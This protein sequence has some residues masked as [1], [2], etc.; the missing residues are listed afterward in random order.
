M[1]KKRTKFLLN[2]TNVIL[3][4]LHSFSIAFAQ[5]KQAIRINGIAAVVGDEII[6]EGD[7]KEQMVIARMQGFDVDNECSV[8]ENQM[9]N[10]LL[11]VK[12]KQDTLIKITDKELD[13]EV[14]RKIQNF[15]LRAGSE[16]ELLKAFRMSSMAEVKMEAKEYVKEEYYGERK[17][18][19]IIGKIDASPNDVRKYFN[20]IKDQLPEVKESVRISHI[21]MYPKLFEKHKEEIRKKLRSMKEDIEAGI[22]TFELKA[23]IYS[24]DPGSAKNGGFYGNVRRGKMVKEFDAV[25]FNLQ[26]G[27]I[28]EPFETEYGFHIIKLEKRKGQALDLRHILLTAKPTDEE[29]L[30]TRAK[31][32]SIKTLIESGK[33]TFKEAV[34]KFSDDKYTRNNEGVVVDPRTGDNQFEKEAL[35]G[36]E[37][38]AVVALEPGQ[39]SYPFE[40]TFEKRTV[41]RM[42]KLDEIIPAH[43]MNLETDYAKIKRAVVEKKK[44]EALKK[45]IKSNISDVFISVSPGFRECDF[46]L[47]WFNDPNFKEKEN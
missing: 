45:W 47:N 35:S 40:D 28:S 1:P 21:V 7:I 24:E 19:M 34:E 5:E 22:S 23:Q 13:A 42:I 18:E 37:Y 9:M 31:M 16:D 8:L 46:E 25:A 43:K 38:I 32:D 26:E 44:D 4:L 11:Y 12:A 30:R 6:L 15:L 33:M 14:D 20:Q 27:E 10:K 2:P 41:I 29:I 36:K 39:L 17:R 3:I